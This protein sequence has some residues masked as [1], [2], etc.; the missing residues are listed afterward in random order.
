MQRRTLLGLL[1]TTIILAM[2]TAVGA[3]PYRHT[4]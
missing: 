4:T 1:A 3:A 2:P